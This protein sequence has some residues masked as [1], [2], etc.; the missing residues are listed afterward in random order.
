M[1]DEVKNILLG[2][3][4]SDPK[5]TRLMVRVDASRPGVVDVTA[6]KDGKSLA[7][8]NSLKLL[9]YLRSKRKEDPEADWNSI[10]FRAIEGCEPTEKFE[11]L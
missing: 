5:G 10:L 7:M 11:K 6:Q 8:P 4:L 1:T 9:M 3:L 2:V